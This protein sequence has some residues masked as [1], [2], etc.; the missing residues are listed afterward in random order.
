MFFK[1][2]GSVD[3]YW[4]NGVKS[5]Y[6]SVLEHDPFEMKENENSELLFQQATVFNNGTNG[7]YPYTSPTG[8]LTPTR[9]GSN[10]NRRTSNSPSQCPFSGHKIDAH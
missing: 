7:N 1:G 8:H 6:A 5:E 10:I 9:R 4:L 3:T 2:K